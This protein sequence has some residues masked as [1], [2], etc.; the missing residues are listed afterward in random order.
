MENGIVLGQSVACG[1]SLHLSR[2]K[3]DEAKKCGENR[4]KLRLK[5]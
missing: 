2:L 5:N 3:K 1:G 4:K